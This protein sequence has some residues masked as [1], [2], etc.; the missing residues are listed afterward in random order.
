MQTLSLHV[1]SMKSRNNPITV[2]DYLHKLVIEI[3]KLQTRYYANG[4]MACSAKAGE[5]LFGKMLGISQKKVIGH[6]GRFDYEKNQQYLID[7][8]KIAAERNFI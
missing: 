3:Q 6:I 2:K 4:Y 5:W 1:D 8:F 7:V